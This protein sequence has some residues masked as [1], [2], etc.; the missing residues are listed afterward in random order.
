VQLASPFV[1]ISGKKRVEAGIF[2]A[3]EKLMTLIGE[4]FEERLRPSAGSY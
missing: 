1:F 2:F 4:H 3:F